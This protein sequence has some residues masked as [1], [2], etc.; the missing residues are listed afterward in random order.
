MMKLIKMPEQHPPLIPS[1]D[2]VVDST[3]TGDIV[4]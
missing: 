4:G 3:G 1:G 2:G